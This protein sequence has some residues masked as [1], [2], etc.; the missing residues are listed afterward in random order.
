MIPL[1][2]VKR[3]A[4]KKHAVDEPWVDRWVVR[5]ISIHLTWLLVHTPLTA[6]QVTLISMALIA[7]GVVCLGAGHPLMPAAG[8]VGMFMGCVFDSCDGEIARFRKATSLRGVYLDTLSHAVTI[9]GMYLAAGIGQFLRHATIES[10]VLGAVAAVAATHPAQIAFMTLTHLGSGGQGASNRH[11]QP[12][13]IGGLKSLYLKTIGRASIFPN[14][15]YV[16]ILAAAADSIFLHDVRRGAIYWALA[17]Y[18]VILG[19]EQIVAA[20]SWSRED[21]LKQGAP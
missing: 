7:G 1:Q 13:S 5:K 3:D 4:A 15:M 6:N 21:R 17:F 19:L 12:A 14:S 18:A 9:P 2:T 8:A 20:V 11:G 10:L 16:F